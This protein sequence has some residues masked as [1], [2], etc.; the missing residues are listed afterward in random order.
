LTVSPVGR[1]PAR[2][3]TSAGTKFDRPEA[4]HAAGP[5][6]LAGRATRCAADRTAI[7]MV[8]CDDMRM[9]VELRL[10]AALL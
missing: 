4:S 5:V 10:C 7:V 9:A 3:G 8:A 2:G 1:P 6:E